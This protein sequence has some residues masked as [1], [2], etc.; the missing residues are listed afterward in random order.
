[1]KLIR[2]LVLNN[3]GSRRKCLELI[4]NGEIKIN[5]D[6]ASDS[7]KDIEIGKD[8]V[9][10]HGKAYSTIPELYYI[11]LNKP[12]GFITTK[13]DP[14]ERPTV[15]DILYD[16]RIFKAA[17]AARWPGLAENKIYKLY[18]CIK[19]MNI[20]YAGRLDFNSQGLIIMSNDGEIV[21]NII[22]D[23]TKIP[24]VYRLKIRNQLVDKHFQSLKHG[25]YF[26]IDNKNIKF[27]CDI[28][29]VHPLKSN[30]LLKITIYSG[31]NR[32]IRRAFD[33]IHRPIVSLK[34]IQVGPIKIR[35]LK[36]GAFRFLTEKEVGSLK[37]L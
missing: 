22:S 24:K 15:Y 13:T 29:E 30:M 36:E 32:V 12:R 19:K 14:E 20:V 27:T 25:V 35:G 23:K 18:K 10:Y 7:T 21:N 1:M 4:K 28:N 6:P 31:E 17:A 3:I 26:K 33:Q 9:R 2:F 37:R 8:T 34:R 11:A 16:K 5:N